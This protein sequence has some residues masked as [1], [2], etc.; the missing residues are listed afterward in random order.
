MIVKDGEFT[1]ENKK[2][3]EGMCSLKAARLV[4]LLLEREKH[5]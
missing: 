2:N 4:T 1:I 5:I 3:E